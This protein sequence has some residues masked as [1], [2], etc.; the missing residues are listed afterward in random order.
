MAE[1]TEW[2]ASGKPIAAP[3]A[4]TEWDANGKP[5]AAAAAAAAAPDTRSLYEKA[6]DNFNANTQGAQPGD[7]PVKG[8]VENIGQGGGQALRALAH[9]IDTLTGMAHTIAHPLDQADAE[10]KALKADPSRFIGNAIGQAGAG[11]IAGEAVAPIAAAIKPTLGRA[12]LVG[13]SPEGAYASALKPSTVLPEAQR[14]A[15]VQTGLEQG[16]PISKGGLETLTDKIDTLNQAIKDQIASDPSRPIDPNSVATRAD[17]AKARFT[18]QVNAQ[19][20]LNAIEASK[21]QFLD[22]QGRKPGQ[23]AIAPKP[24]GILDAQ[25]TPIMNGGTPAKPPTPAPPMNAEDAQAMKQGTY[26]VLSGKFGE[27]GSA[28]VEAQK[29]LARGLKEEIATQFPEI[30]K[31]NASES[32]LLDLQPL[33]ERAVARVGNHESP[34]GIAGPILGAGVK[35]AT[36]S[37]GLA[38]VASVLKTVVDIPNIKSRLAIAVSKANKIPYTD[39]VNKI[40]AYSESLGATAAS[41]QG[42]SPADT[43]NQ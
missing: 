42:N 3:A 13:R 23:P 27:Q 1:V 30:G 39:A 41:T 17:A 28:S 18:N 20:D 8:F 2:D 38:A 35:A 25:G 43:P 40:N 33:L 32:R 11:A 22:E 26:R 34:V 6:R 9:P 37:T 36:N 15:A 5:I 21:Q 14:A 4:P 31:L 7:N 10:V 16:I 12:V 24:T 29:A 19:S